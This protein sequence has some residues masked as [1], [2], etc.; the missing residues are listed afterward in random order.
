MNEITS[1]LSVNTAFNADAI[2]SAIVVKPFYHCTE[3][4]IERR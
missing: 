3:V 4:L 1:E 2:F